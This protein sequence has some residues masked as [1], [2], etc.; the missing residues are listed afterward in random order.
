MTHYCHNCRELSLLRDGVY[1]GWCLD[2]FYSHDSG[3]PK[4]GDRN[5]TTLQRMYT[6]LGWGDAPDV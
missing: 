2:W 3:L 1:C 5:P 4:H 6:Q